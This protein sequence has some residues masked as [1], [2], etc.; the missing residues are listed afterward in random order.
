VDNWVSQVSQMLHEGV[1]YRPIV[2]TIPA[3]LRTTFSQHTKDVLSPFMRGGMRCLDDVWSRLSGQVL[4]GG[5]IVVMQT[6]GRNGQYNPP[7]HILATSGG[8]DPHAKQWRPLNYVPYRMLRKKWPWPLLTMLR[9]TVKTQE[10]KRLVDVCY[11]RYREGCVTN[12][13]KGDVPARD[14]SVARYLA[15]YVVSPPISLKRIDRYDGQRV[16]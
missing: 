10:M 11:T 16:P 1:I 5:S 6:H 12:V 14:Q 7:L 2:L 9:Q 13:H 4:T 15:Q 3:M 8:G